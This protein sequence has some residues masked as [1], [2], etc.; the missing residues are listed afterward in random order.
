M[1]VFPSRVFTVTVAVP[2]FLAVTNPVIESMVAAVPSIFH[3]II[4]FES[5]GV[6]VNAGLMV[7]PFT[8]VYDGASNAIV[9]AGA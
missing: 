9:S 7:L 4:S 5:W 8:T 2:I 3:A 6:T 1:A